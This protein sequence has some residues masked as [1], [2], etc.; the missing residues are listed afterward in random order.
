MYLF[1][2]S[3]VTECLLRASQNIWSPKYLSTMGETWVWLLDWEDPLEK[4]KVTHFSILAWRIPGTI[5]SPWGCK[6]SDTT[7]Q[8]AHTVTNIIKWKWKLLSRVQLFATPRTVW[9]SL[10]QNTEGGSL[11][12]LQGI[13]PTQ[14]S[15]PDLPHCRQILHQLSHKGS[16]NII[17][18]N[19]KNFPQNWVV[20]DLHYHGW[21]NGG[22]ER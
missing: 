13:L 21:R 17:E 18:L 1:F 14:G 7:E 11:S 9:N 16:P 8:L 10:G 6:E 19:F 12:L 22:S 15:N 3:S 5:Y 4:G 20:G 2:A